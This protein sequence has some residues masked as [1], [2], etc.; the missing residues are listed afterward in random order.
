MNPVRKISHAASVLPE[1]TCEILSGT[2][3]A[4]AGIGDF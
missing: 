3:V 1:A 4:F 2:V